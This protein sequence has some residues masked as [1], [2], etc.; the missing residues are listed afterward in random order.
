[1]MLRSL[2][3]RQRASEW[4]DAPDADPVLLDHSLRFLRRIN[5]LLRYT[6]STITH[7]E[8][9][10]RTWNAG[11][12]IRII[13]FATG[14]ADIPRAIVRWADRRRLKVQ[15]IGVDLHEHTAQMARRASLDPRIQIVRANVLALPFPDQSFDYAITSLFLHHLSEEQIIEVLRAMDRV[16]RRG[17]IAADLIRNRRAYAWITLFT[18]FANPMVRHDARVSVAQAFSASE[19]LDLARHSGLSYL[20]LH[21]HFAHRFVLAG[22]KPH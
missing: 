12:I 19:A 3:H 1:M 13:D 18:L 14:S 20:Q 4:M 11:E 7:L 16:A 2:A 6:R 22:E 21:T 5:R 15:I 10:S 8:R 9:F 17:I